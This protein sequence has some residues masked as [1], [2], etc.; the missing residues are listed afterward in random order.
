LSLFSEL[1][2]SYLSPHGAFEVVLGKVLGVVRRCPKRVLGYR[3]TEKQREYPITNT[4]FP[5]SKVR[6]EPDAARLVQQDRFLKVQVFTCS[7]GYSVLAV[8][9]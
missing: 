2:A 1:K 8:G 9:Y 6:R 4:E 7:V 3:K 5:I